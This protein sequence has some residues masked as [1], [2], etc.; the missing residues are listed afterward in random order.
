MGW[1]DAD[2][3]WILRNSWG[4]SWGENGYMRIKYTSARVAC[5]ATYLVYSQAPG[6]TVTAPA[7][8]GSWTVGTSQAITWTRTGALD[9]NVKIELFKGGVKAWD[10]AATTANDGSHDWAIP[11]TLTAGTDYMVRITTADG[12]TSDDSDLFAITI[13]TAP[14]LTVTSPV[15]G[16]TWKRSSKYNI[17]WTKTGTQG[18]NVKIR[19]TATARSN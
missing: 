6:I 14:T 10:I 17:L 7:A 9:A 16:V 2:G 11:T 5:E 18:A 3:A 13:T 15:A 12:A 1:N 8:G 4:P 19:S